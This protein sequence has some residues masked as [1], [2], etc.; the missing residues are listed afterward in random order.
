M[1]KKII[2]FIAA[3]V[4]ILIPSK[5][6]SASVYDNAY[7]YYSKYGS[8]N[9][10]PAMLNEDDGYIYFCSKGLT[11][12]TSTQYRT[13]GYTITLRAGGSTDSVEVKLGGTYIR[14]VSEVK[15]NGYTYV[16]RRAKL[17][18]L[19]TLFNGNNDI[20]W[21]QI[22]CNKNT[23]RFDAIMTV[24]ENG[25]LLCGN[26]KESG[27]Y[28]TI[29]A[30]DNSYLFRTASGIKK[31]RKWANPKDL[32]SFFNKSVVFVPVNYIKARDIYA[33]G[34]SGNVFYD[35][36]NYYVK[37]GSVIRVAFE[38]YF[39]DTEAASAV[40][41]PNYNI[42][43]V[44]GWG[45]NQ[46]YYTMQKKN[47]ASGE[48]SG[49]IKD[50]TGRDKPLT[51]MNTVT[52]GTTNYSGCPY[53]FKSMVRF[54]FNTPDGSVTYI[55]PEGRVYY[56][57][58]YPDSLSDNSDMCN[59]SGDSGSVLN[60]ISDD[61]V[62]DVYVPDCISAING[63]SIPV[64]VFDNGSGIR[65]ISVCRSDGAV[66]AVKNY[67][68]RVTEISEDRALSISV[69]SRYKY[70][71]RAIDNVGNV[72][73][74]GYLVFSVPKAHTVNAYIAGGVNGY[75]SSVITSN[76]YGGN[77]EIAALVIMS[78]EENNPSKERVVF[79]N[80]SVMAHT[81]SSGMYTYRYS[82]NPMYL[83]NTKPDGEYHIDV[84]SGGKYVASD[85]VRLVL[86]KDKTD[87]TVTVKPYVDEKRWHRN[88]L[89]LSTEVSDNYSGADRLWI[90]S[91]N[92]EVK[93]KITD[94]GGIL[95]GYHIISS[96]GE[97]SISINASDIAGNTKVMRIKYMIDKT[98]PKGNLE[99]TFAG[100]DSENDI[101]LNREGLY[102]ELHIH[103][104]LSGVSQLDKNYELLERFTGRVAEVD[105][106]NPYAISIKDNKNAVISFSE[107]FINA[108]VSSTHQYIFDYLDVAG[109]RQTT[110][111]YL[112]IDC[113]AP[114]VDYKCDN[115]W[116]KRQLKGNVHIT[117]VHSGIS[118]IELYR[119]DIQ[120]QVLYDV[121][122]NEYT[123]NVDMSKYVS[124]SP[125][126]YINVTDAAGNVTKH[127][128]ANGIG[129][130]LTASIRRID[131]FNQPIFKAGENAILN[132]GF[133]GQADVIKVFFP[134]QLTEYDASLNREYDISGKGSFY[135]GSGFN[136]PIKTENGP[137]HVTVIACRDDE[138]YAV[139][140]PFEV[141]GCITQQF[142]TRIR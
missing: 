60:L 53:A 47:S 42:Y 114:V 30:A 127:Q 119:N 95:S 101:W 129:I 124:E 23:Y 72:R 93:G 12:S 66:E 6:T 29:S 116:N 136:I 58:R 141:Y 91:N 54:G 89:A 38:S 103:D 102:G 139:Y 49:I 11:A 10:N 63:A 37:K 125:D 18:L 52:A 62:P 83:L 36:G 61:K 122:K 142:R 14:E 3:F 31:A 110:N 4:V 105:F 104:E 109:N 133:T 50:G 108:A 138:E 134:E 45:D 87:P 34:E 131:G 88:N 57:Y 107:K 65:S 100:L 1:G 59:K 78:E 27:N 140:A 74:T 33:E 92:E 118:S 106:D 16:L 13:V 21:N 112:N 115:S 128:L 46:K 69:D 113:T 67:S 82:F 40:F 70:Y 80:Q 97:N 77:S 117:D 73:S 64:S 71:V 32:D 126:I 25:R 17:S 123:I 5:I 79:V 51:F 94:S 28:R 39:D 7:T 90:M 44:S 130:K 48:Y 84:I 35:N 55:K 76:V 96:E 120:E 111:L 121:N 56:N 2:Y 22:Y 8:E 75:N 15:K 24:V 68:G 98:P 43:H 81:M 20:S 86:K 85:P 135:L 26:I 132:I 137:Y 19:Q 99:K 41:H 9:V